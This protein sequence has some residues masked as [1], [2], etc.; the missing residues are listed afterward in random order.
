VRMREGALARL[1]SESH[2]L[3]GL[4]EECGPPL[5]RRNSRIRMLNPE[6][7]SYNR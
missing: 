5:C 4:T 3:S 6:T 7:I 1:L 2:E